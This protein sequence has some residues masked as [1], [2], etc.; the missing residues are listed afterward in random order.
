MLIN[1]LYVY[2]GTKTKK[3]KM[4]KTIV[5]AILALAATVACKKDDPIVDPSTALGTAT[6]SGIV[7]A[8]LNNPS[9]GLEVF[10]SVPIVA[11]YNRADLYLDPPS[12]TFPDEIKSTVSDGNGLY[13]IVVECGSVGLPV[14]IRTQDVRK[15]VVITTGP[16]QTI[17]STVFAS[18]T[19]NLNV[20]KNGVFIQDI[21]L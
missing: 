16:P 2:Y 20:Y 4:K 15:D 5:L 13:S 12:N 21:N 3:K 18:Q 8:E 14:K 10:A 7:K 6:I 1:N 11:I 17:Q 19:Y 9:A